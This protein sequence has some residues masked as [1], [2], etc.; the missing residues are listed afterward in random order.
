MDKEKPLAYSWNKK[1]TIGLTNS[2]YRQTDFKIHKKYTEQ[3]N[4]LETNYCSKFLTTDQRLGIV[5]NNI[6][7][8]L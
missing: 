7:E 2:A 5:Y 6:N 3:K 4:N 1:S 8:Y